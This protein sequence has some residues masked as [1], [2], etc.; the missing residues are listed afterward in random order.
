MI[1]AQCLLLLIASL[2][3]GADLIESATTVT[4]T[5]RQVALRFD[6]RDGKLR[7]FA[8]NGRELLG[9]GGS[10]YIQCVAGTKPEHI[11]WSYRVVRREPALVDIEFAN[12]NPRFPFELA[13]RYVLRG[14]E[15]GFY[16]YIVLGHDAQKHPG[17]FHMG[18]LDFCLRADPKL[19]TIAA[20]DDDRITP[21]PKPES[22]R[23]APSVTDATYRLPDGSIYS[24]YFSSATMDERHTVHGVMGDGLGLWIVMPSHEHLNGGPERQELTVHQTDTTPVLLRHYVAGHYGASGIDSSN[25]WT[26]PSAPW[27]V[28]ANAGSNLWADAKRRAAQEVAAW[29]YPWFDKTPRGNITGKITAYARVILASHEENPPSL[30]WQQQWQGYRYYCWADTDGRFTLRNVRS[31]LYDLYA[32]KPAV[33][34]TFIQRGVR[35]AGDINLGELTWTLP[36]RELLWQIGVPDRSAAEFGFAE[37]FRQWGLWNTIPNEINFVVGKNKD[38]D[39]PFEMAITQNSDLSWRLPVWRI[40]FERGTARTGK[41]VLTLAFAESE[42]N[43]LRHGPTVKVSLNGEE[44]VQISDLA[45]D[46]AAHRSGISGL[47]QVREIPFDAA[48]LRDGVNTLTLEMPRQLRPLKTLLGIPAA[49]VM[50]DC[51]RLELAP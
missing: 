1:K 33:I 31:G 4:L 20:V 25:T 47:Y 28:Y 17:T 9:N 44:L 13:T 49:A 45:T 34:G 37:N 43:L 12:A 50:F 29:P 2:A 27:F 23:G 30:D 26:Q 3:R 40:Q 32:W 8:F 5:N 11:A 7:S 42:S 51:L 24:K 16:N 15:P 10:G 36:R 18:Q 38:R 14:D 48:K 41:A 6:K 39:L 35:V 19:F 46:G 21:F 22:L